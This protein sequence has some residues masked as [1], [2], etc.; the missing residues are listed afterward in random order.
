[1]F[2]VGIAKPGVA[3]IS[4]GRAGVLGLDLREVVLFEAH[5]AVAQLFDGGSHVAL[6]PTTRECAARHLQRAARRP[7]VAYCR[8][9]DRSLAHQAWVH[10][11]RRGR[12]SR[13]RTLWRLLGPWAAWSRLIVLIAIISRSSTLACCKLLALFVSYCR[14]DGARRTVPGL[15]LERRSRLP[16][17]RRRPEEPQRIYSTK[18]RHLST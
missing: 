13:R 3:K 10:L 17:Q 4:S 12:V 7:R 1:M 6:L 16:R 9:I 8:R 15:P 11:R 18:G 2:A 5:A 14:R